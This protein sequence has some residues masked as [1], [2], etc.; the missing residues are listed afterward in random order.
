MNIVDWSNYKFHCSGLSNLMVASRKKD[1]PLSETTKSYLLEI[2]IKEVFGREKSETVA[3][4]YMQKG[5]MCETDSLELVER[6][7]GK[8]FFK[9]QETLSNEYIVG[10]PDVKQEE[11]IDI[12]TSWD[13]F[14]FMNVDEEQAEKD[15]FH[16]LLGYMWLTGHRTAQLSYCLVNTPE[17]LVGDEMYRLSFKLPEDQVEKYRKNYVF[18]DIPESMRIKSYGFEYNEEIVEE[19]KVKILL[20]RDYLSRLDAQLKEKA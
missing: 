13:L 8:K 10:T 7:T 17:I 20:C 1:D 14:T 5:T 18:D 2:F 12:K 4:K 15:Y 6:V 3:N 16:Q 9:N 11:L 19:L